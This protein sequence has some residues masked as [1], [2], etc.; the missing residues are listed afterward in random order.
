MTD[1]TR[2]PLSSYREYPPEEMQARARA[3]CEEMRGRRSVRDFSPRPIP[4]EVI[5][6]C[7]EAAA[8]AP[9]GANMQPWHFVVV[10][11]A[12]AKRQIREAAEREEY[13]FY[14][15][16]AGDEWLSDL[17]DLGTDVQKPFLET[18][19]VLIAVFA[20]PYG[21]LADGGKKKHYYVQTSVGIATGML[22]AA[23][24]HAGLG[25][26]TYTPARMAFLREMLNRPENERPFVVL[27]SGYP[28]EGAT[29][30]NLKKKP[31]SE[32]TTFV[33]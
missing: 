17:S 31:L 3:F 8:S 24:H 16:V 22:V 6:A 11:D 28:A 26:L 10:T 27:V 29:V 23:L 12:T 18:A 20:Q 25:V 2:V 4:S 21:L 19:P 1:E 30:P 15:G 5:E 13:A 33:T 9:S 14:H 32:V 7:L